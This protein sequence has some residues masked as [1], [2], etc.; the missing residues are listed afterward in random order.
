MFDYYQSLTNVNFINV[1]CLTLG[2]TLVSLLMSSWNYFENRNN[3]NF[4]DTF[5][6]FFPVVLLQT[7][8]TLNTIAVP[9]LVRHR[10]YHFE[11]GGR[12]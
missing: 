6:S 10:S 7:L 4:K 11:A 2:I 3:L 9:I 5:K 1:L 8:L 12:C